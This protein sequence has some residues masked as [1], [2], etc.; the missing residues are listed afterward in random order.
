MAFS[1][2]VLEQ[3]L[4]PKLY[5]KSGDIPGVNPETLEKFTQ[6]TNEELKLARSYL[7]TTK[8]NMGITS[9]EIAELEKFDGSEFISNSYEFI[10]KKLG[11]G[12]DV[13]PTG[14]FTPLGKDINMLYDPTRNALL[15]NSDRVSQL[16]KKSTFAIIRHELQHAL[17][18]Y[19]VLRHDTIGVKAIDSYALEFAKSEIQIFANYCQSIPREEFTKMLPQTPEGIKLLGRYDKV[20]N[21]IEKNDN[22]ELAILTTELI[23]EYKISMTQFRNKLIQKFGKIPQNS[24]LTPKIEKFYNASKISQF[25]DNGGV[26][27]NRWIRDIREIDA[28]FATTAAYNEY[29]SVNSSTCPAKNY[30]NF[31]KSVI[32]DLLKNQT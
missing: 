21:I 23:D 32:E 2:N 8:Y 12:N 9:R 28:D 15:I 29:Q 11:L 22:N 25:K 31:L 14:N 27:M 17:Q 26:D 18:N 16:D 3:R 1:I 7:I 4:G 6:Q 13:R 30:K 5:K 24:S 20:K 19:M 10:A